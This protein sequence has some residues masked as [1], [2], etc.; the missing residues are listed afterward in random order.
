MTMLTLWNGQDVPRIGVGCWAIGGPFTMDGRADGWGDVDDNQ[1]LRALA[2]AYDL[3]ARL[4]DTADAYGTGHSEEVL[5]QAMVGRPDAVIATKFGYAH[6][7]EKR[8]LTGTDVTPAYMEQALAASLKR[9]GRER[10]V[11]RLRLDGACQVGPAVAHLGVDV[12]ADVGAG[13]A[14]GQP[15]H[16]R[17]PVAQVDAAGQFHRQAEPHAGHR[18]A[19]RHQPRL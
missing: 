11:Q 4:F 15:G 12:A 8:A 5:G 1:S 18:H 7:R 16:H 19:G 6:D 9:L 10:K 3:G 2:L 13:D 14:A 17:Q